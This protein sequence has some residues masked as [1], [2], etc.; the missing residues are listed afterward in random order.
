MRTL[1]R[2][3]AVAYMLAWALVVP[4]TAD[5]IEADP[6]VQLSPNSPTSGELVDSPKKW[7]GKTLSFTGE[8]IGEKMQ[9]GE[10]AWIHVNDDAY[11]VKNIEEGASLGGYNSGH[12][13][14]LTD[15]LASRIR[16]FG[17]YT[18]EGDI[19]T[20][21]GTFNAA[22][23]QHGGDMDIHAEGLTID[24]PGHV[25][26]ERVHPVKLAVGLIL[27]VLALVF[28]MANRRVEHRE[29]TGFFGT[30]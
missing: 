12:A 25:V 4:V 8:A 2:A 18:H 19:I 28:W 9:R 5:A 3:T 21:R 13:V 11:Y 24:K 7:D 27:A 14:W 22:C 30:S 16:T 1:L 29:L 10:Y 15:E 23:G 26:R 6:S 20:V 17:D